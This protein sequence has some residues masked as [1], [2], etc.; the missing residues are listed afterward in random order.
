MVE[1]NEGFSGDARARKEVGA[2]CV[3]EV[4]DGSERPVT[5][6]SFS[7]DADTSEVQFNTGFHQDIAVTGVSYSGSFELAGRNESVRDAAWGDGTNAEQTTLPEYIS[8]MTIRAEDSSW[9]ATF[10]NVLLNS[11]SKDMP[12]DDRTSD[13][14]DFM[15]EKMTYTT[16]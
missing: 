14:Y 9:A 4:P 15:A 11:R 2:E 5:N 13:S 12:A 16:A 3:L 7:E 1:F 6:V 8:T 10:S